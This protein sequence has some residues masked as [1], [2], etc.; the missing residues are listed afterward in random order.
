LALSFRPIFRASHGLFEKEALMELA[1]APLED[2]FVRL[3]PINERHR[4]GLRAA[5][6]AD[7]VVWEAFYAYSMFGEHFDITWGRLNRDAASGT[8]QPYVVVVADQCVGI[9][10]Y[11][12]I[13]QAHATLEI[14]GTYYRPEFRGGPTNPAAKRLL[15]A[16]A[17]DGGVRRVQLK[18]DAINLRSRAAV[19]KLGATQEGVLRQDRVTWTGRLRDTVVFSIL[20]EEWPAVREGLDRRLTDL[21]TQAV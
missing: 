10:C 6:A 14:G 18:V 17:F 11:L 2:R 8:W 15:L 13:D 9:S 19:L 1:F 21:A 4:D 12:G 3:E 7:P 16:H 20:A 5:C